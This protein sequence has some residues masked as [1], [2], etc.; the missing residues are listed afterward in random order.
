MAD[1]VSP[2][3][4]AIRVGKGWMSDLIAN[5]IDICLE[6]FQKDEELRQ[7]AP[8][9]VL[10]YPPDVG[11]VQKLPS[12]HV[13]C[14][15]CLFD[16]PALGQQHPGQNFRTHQKAF[17]NIQYIH[18][19]NTSHNTRVELMAV[20]SFLT[21]H[22]RRNQNLNG[23]VNGADINEVVIIDKTYVVKQLLLT[24]SCLIHAA[25]TRELVDVT[26]TVPTK[27]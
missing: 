21:D 6:A 11:P 1:Y 20:A 19:S 9:S 5:V 2:N 3:L 22:L 4:N 15:R 26:S 24:Q 18:S 16:T 17:L 23:L 12:L 14:S 10:C 27:A 13:W 8:Q 7:Y 25:Y